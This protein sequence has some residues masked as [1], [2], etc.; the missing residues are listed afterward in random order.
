MPPSQPLI[1]ESIVAFVSR[2]MIAAGVPEEPLQAH[3]EA[4]GVRPEGRGRV[5]WTEYRALWAL[6]E[7]HAAA[8]AG[9]E[10][11]DDLGIRVALSIPFGARDLAD[12]VL[13]SAATLGQVVRVTLELAPR[14]DEAIVAGVEEVGESLLIRVGRAP[15]LDVPPAMSDYAI[16][17]LVGSLR[18]LM[19]ERLVPERVF[20]TRPSPRRDDAHRAYYG[21]PVSFGHAF[22]GLQIPSSWRERPL[23]GRDEALHQ[24]LLKHT[25]RALGASPGAEASM[26]ERVRQLLSELIG[27]GKEI[28]QELVARRLSQSRRTLRR[29][30]AAEGT[31]YAELYDQARLDYAQTALRAGDTIESVAER[32]GFASPGS[33]S[34]AFRRWVGVPPDTWRKGADD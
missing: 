8:A 23:P 6:A 16:A 9:A 20:L 24:T 1:A 28:Q 25:R 2:A 26:I 30:L 31:T 34:R 4:M 13:R 5:A 7:T 22:E 29:A 27:E 18:D 10:A 15:G 3:L 12:F 33:F 14:F 32:L 19:A 21:C 17:R 11:D